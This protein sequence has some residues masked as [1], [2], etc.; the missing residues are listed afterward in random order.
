MGIVYHHISPLNLETRDS[1]LSLNILAERAAIASMAF[2]AISPLQGKGYGYLDCE[3]DVVD[4]IKRSL[5]WAV[6]RGVK[7]RVKDALPNTFFPESVQREEV[8]LEKDKRKRV[9]KDGDGP[10]AG[11]TLPGPSWNWPFSLPPLEM[12][13][14][15]LLSA[16]LAL[17]PR[18]KLSF[19]FS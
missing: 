5:N 12:K 2:H 19:S 13:I 4:E 3:W 15:G 18:N 8:Y 17:T 11:S 14:F 1:L 9:K 16:T 10:L 7:V 6:F